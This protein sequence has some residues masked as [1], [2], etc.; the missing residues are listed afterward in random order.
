MSEKTLSR[1][2]MLRGLGVAIAL[3]FLEAMLPRRSRGQ[4]ATAPQRFMGW[5][6]PNGFN[7]D[8][9][10]PTTE[11]T[12]FTLPPTL[13]PLLPVQ[14][15]L[16]VLSGLTLAGTGVNLGS[17][18]G[19][20]QALFT[21]VANIVPGV[22]NSVDQVIAQKVG[23]GTALGSLQLGIELNGY[24]DP[25]TDA[26]NGFIASPTA[27]FDDT[28]DYCDSDDCKAAVVQGSRLPNMYN[29]RLVFQQLFGAPPGGT[30]STSTGTSSGQK[31]DAYRK[32]ILDAV[33]ADANRLSQ[34]VGTADKALLD[35]Y[36]TGVRQIESSIQ[37]ASSLQACAP[38]TQPI[39]IPFT[40]TA[41]ARLM[42][43]LVVKAFQ[44]DATRVATM[45][46]GRTTSPMNFTVDGVVYSHHNDASHWGTDPV[47]KHAKDFIDNWQV[48]QLAYLLQQM[49]AITE[50]GGTMLDNVVVFYSSDVA[51]PNL[52]NQDNMPVLLAGRGGGVFRTGRHIKTDIAG[53]TTGDLFLTILSAFGIQQTRFGDYGK[54]ALG[55]LS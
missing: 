13:A 38:G 16:L 26:G 27:S 40:P 41:R 15:Y 10:T 19:G 9:W 53:R 24:Y 30:T 37:N 33:T 3:P 50:P 7:A 11:G 45:M 42:C 47:K 28:K 46:L 51:D 32:S 35:Q 23:S 43:D 49:K 48:S 21:S 31:S 54:N 12:S 36:L 4:S 18:Q 8:M 34:K 22:T 2:S 14:D 1:R 55:G 44:C 17:H 25:I 6:H 39:G 52:H 5:F 20:E 29:P